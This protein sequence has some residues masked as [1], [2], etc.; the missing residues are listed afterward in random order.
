MFR[1]FRTRIFLNEMSRADPYRFAQVTEYRTQVRFGRRSYGVLLAPN[2]ERWQPQSTQTLDR[3]TIVVGAWMIVPN[4]NQAR[5]HQRGR[6]KLLR[7]K[8]RIVCGRLGVRQLAVH[9]RRVHQ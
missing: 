5:K 8:R 6:L 4:R 2:E 9:Q 1:D 7:W 3:D